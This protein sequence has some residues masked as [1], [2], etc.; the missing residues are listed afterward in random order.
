MHKRFLV[1]A[2]PI[3]ILCC[4]LLVPHSAFAQLLAGVHLGY[5]RT[6]YDQ[7]LG[8]KN[9]TNTEWSSGVWANYRHEDL[10]FTGFYQGSLGLQEFNAS[11]HLAHIGANYRFLEEDM[12]QVY[13][14]LGYQLVS[15]R[16]STPQVDSGKR[17]TLTG[18]GFSGQVVVDIAITD[19]FRSRATVIANPWTKWAHAADGVTDTN[20]DSGHAFVY[21]LE[22]YYD[23]STD[24]GA[25][26]SVLGNTYQVPGFSRG[27]MEIGETKSSAVSINLGVTRHF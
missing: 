19:E 24:F 13:G 20:I 25:H 1:H 27:N 12:L 21:K 9:L 14:G 26:L 2:L 23:F 4:F 17:N 16:F 11:R 5:G 8:E 7:V 6:S 10:L 18:H 15:T 3:L 22:L